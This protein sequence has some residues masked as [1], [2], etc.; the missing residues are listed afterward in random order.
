MYSHGTSH[1]LPSSAGSGNLSSCPA[2][3]DSHFVGNAQVKTNRPFQ[4]L[5]VGRIEAGTTIR[6]SLID[7]PHFNMTFVNDYRDLWI[8]SKQHMVD[9]IVMQ[10]TLC[11]FELADAARLARGRWPRA[12]ILVIRSGELFLDRQFYDE[13]MHPPV[14]QDVLIKRVLK[15]S[16]SPREGE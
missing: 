15:L 9:T 3:F 1:G 5:S 8:F 4:V 6:D 7:S 14:C 13:R 2:G 10:N 11:S 12:R 16:K